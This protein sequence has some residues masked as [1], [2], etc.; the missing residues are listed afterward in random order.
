M[1]VMGRSIEGR[2]KENLAD[3]SSVSPDL[4]NV[5]IVAKHQGPNVS[6]NGTVPRTSSL[7]Q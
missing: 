2:G 7:K 5:Y 1:L 3:R 4:R 6:R